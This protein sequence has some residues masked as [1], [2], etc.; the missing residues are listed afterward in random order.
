MVWCGS[1]VKPGQDTYIGLYSINRAEWVIAEQACNAYSIVTVPLY[2][3]LGL[4]AVKYI[5][6]QGM[7]ATC[8]LLPP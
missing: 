8:C 3:T 4:E 7:S 6:G 2:D 5:I 1:G